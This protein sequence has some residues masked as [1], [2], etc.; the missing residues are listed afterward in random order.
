MEL[1]LDLPQRLQNTYETYCNKLEAYRNDQEN[2]LV[3]E[4]RETLLNTL[5]ASFLKA[6]LQASI[7]FDYSAECIAYCE[8]IN[9]KLK[10]KHSPY[11]FST[12]NL[13]YPTTNCS[14]E[15]YHKVSDEN[16]RSI[17]SLLD[18]PKAALSMIAQLADTLGELTALLHLVQQ[19]L[20]KKRLPNTDL[21][22]F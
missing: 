10:D 9:A 15:Q 18:D 1:L 22:V 6:L 8:I 14:L 19:A 5:E 12:E 3:I 4:Q 11:I 7:D 2:I 20:V 13:L 21:Y 17:I 16:L